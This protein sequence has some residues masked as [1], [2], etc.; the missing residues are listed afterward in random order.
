MIGHHNSQP[1]RSKLLPSPIPLPIDVITSLLPKG[2]LTICFV[3]GLG[4]KGK[5]PHLSSV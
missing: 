3:R 5:V 2:N 1:S 4:R